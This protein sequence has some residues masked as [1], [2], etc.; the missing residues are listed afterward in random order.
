M[1]ELTFDFSH[2]AVQFSKIL[3]LKD[4]L[5]IVEESSAD[6]L[7]KRSIILIVLGLQFKVILIHLI[8]L[9]H[10]L[11]ILDSLLGIDHFVLLSVFVK[12]DQN[13]SIGDVVQKVFSEDVLVVQ[14]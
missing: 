7:V 5:L 8:L 12:F 14:V 11:S 10:P 4:D 13:N 9:S 3:R 2:V 6:I 1:L